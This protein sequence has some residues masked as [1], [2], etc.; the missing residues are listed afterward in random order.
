VLAAPVFKEIMEES[1]EYLGVKRRQEGQERTPL[2]LVPNLTNFT[3][4]EAEARLTR[5]G[6]PWTMEG[7]GTLVTDQT[8]K[9]G[10]RVPVQTTVHL[11]FYEQEAEDVE[12]P[13]VIGLSM[14]DATAALSD[15]GLRI[16]VVGSGIAKE[17]SPGPGTR[18]PKGSAVEVVFRL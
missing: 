5:E 15:L 10:T 13:S 6:F 11:F 8:P 7:G 18:I 14:R 3:R 4:E 16:T 9:P 2:A 1:L 12:V 17:Q